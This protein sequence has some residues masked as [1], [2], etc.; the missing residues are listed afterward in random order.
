LQ[1]RRQEDWNGV[2]LE[3][4]KAA[5]S[6]RTPKGVWG[7]DRSR[8]WSELSRVACWRRGTKGGAKRRPEGRRD[9]C[10]KKGGRVGDPPYRPIAAT[11]RE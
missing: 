10:E 6:R 8:A 5:A 2:V 1:K 9:V 11:L 4:A 3:I 7:G